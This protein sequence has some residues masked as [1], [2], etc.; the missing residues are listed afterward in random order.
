MSS[1]DEEGK[2]N[3]GMEKPPTYVKPELRT[4]VVVADETVAL[5]CWRAN[6]SSC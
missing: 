3:E 2:K 5:G 4:I 1:N 6:P